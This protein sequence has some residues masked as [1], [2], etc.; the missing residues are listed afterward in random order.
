MKRTGFKN[1]GAGLARG[2]KPLKRRKRLGPGK[3]SL[4][5]A[6]A[7]HAALDA[8]FSRFPEGEARCQ[9]SERIITRETA[10]AHHKTPRSELRK[11]GVEDVD[12]PHRLLILHEDTHIALHD[13]KMGRPQD[14]VALARFELVEQCEANAENALAVF[15][16]TV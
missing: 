6:A 12:A 3:K 10:V 5:R 9:L 11:A 14:P 13:Y 8:Y 4:A 2:T 16:R 1:R 15:R 7:I